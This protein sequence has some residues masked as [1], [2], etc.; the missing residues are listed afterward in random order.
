VVTWPGREGRRADDGE[1]RCGRRGCPAG[2]RS[3]EGPAKATDAAEEEEKKSSVVSAPDFGRRSGAR[4]VAVRTPLRFVEPLNAYLQLESCSP[5]RRVQAR[6]AYNAVRRSLTRAPA[7][8]I[9]YSSGNHGQAL[10]V[11]GAVVGVR[12]VVVMPETAPAVTVAA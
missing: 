1:G 11:R 4:G 9:H 10:G 8:G 6:G 3:Q 5:S 7:R 2:E 12:A